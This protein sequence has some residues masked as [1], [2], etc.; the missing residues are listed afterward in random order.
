MRSNWL[1]KLI[2]TILLVI[3]Y[4]RLVWHGFSPDT[5]DG[6]GSFTMPVVGTSFL[7]LMGASHAAYLVYKATPKTPLL[8]TFAQAAPCGSVFRTKRS[9]LVYCRGG[10]EGRTDLD[11][12][13]RIRGVKCEAGAA[14]G[15]SRFPK[16][17]RI[18]VA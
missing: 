17:P 13:I 7:T 16:G 4:S 12:S 5:I 6:G 3:V 18:A 11:V 9:K 14:S 2:A 15:G 8:C 10:G 1:Q